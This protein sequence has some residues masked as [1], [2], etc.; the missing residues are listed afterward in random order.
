MGGAAVLV[1][2]IAKPAPAQ[3]AYL[4]ASNTAAGDSFGYSVAISGDTLVVGAR[5][6]SGSATGVNGNQQVRRSTNAGTA[7]AFVRRG[8]NWTQEAY[9]KASNA[10]PGD[11]FGSS[12]A[13]SGDTVVVGAEW[14]GSSRFHPA[15]KDT[16]AR[17]SG[18]AFVFVRKG[19]NW[20][21]QVCLKPD[22]ARPGHGFGHS[23]AVSDDVVVVGAIHDSSN[24]SGVNGNRTNTSARSA[25][26]AYVF[27]RRGTNWTQEAY[28]K[29]S[30]PD[31][32]DGFG[33][34]VAVSGSTVVVGAWWE[35]SKATGVNGDQAD[36][37][38]KDAGAAYVFVRNGTNWTQQAYL[39][40][41]N[42]GLEDYFGKS[43]AISGDV[44]VIGAENERSS[45]V[46]S[47]AAYIFVREGTNWSQQAHLKAPKPATR[48]HM[49][50]GTSVAISGEI[51]VVGAV[52]E[53]S[54]TSGINGDQNNTNAPNSGAAYVFV[55]NG[56]NWNQQY[57][58][59]A[60]NPD[61]CV[62]RAYLDILGRLKTSSRG[63]CDQF[64]WSVSASGRSVV[65][66]A[67]GE[68]SK[69]TG[70]NGNQ[71]DNSVPGAGA[72]YVFHGIEIETKTATN[73]L[74]SFEP[75]RSID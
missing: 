61:G 62:G 3:Q 23:V 25:G 20:M 12:V 8:T 57:Y 71:S 49:A 6:E 43:V 38:A 46:N 58:L 30:N 26:A 36:N 27:V 51:V 56:T 39:K 4:K 72:A 15:R 31:R 66:G 1:T 17:E 22:N 37:S 65:V 53:A 34:A 41:S 44:V 54:G 64:G 63:T 9:L 52:G 7:Y 2:P 42:P 29:A 14:D 50:F 55:R 45:R 68:A 5:L 10:G 70:I 47:G 59:K 13:M 75:T 24:S 74:R 67:I 18:S 73:R 16:N 21:E 48:V 28:L 32:E 11:A 40:A 19:T 33:K 69:A 35:D 60:S